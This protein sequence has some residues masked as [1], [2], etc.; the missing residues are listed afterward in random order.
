MKNEY[1]FSAIDFHCPQI[2]EKSLELLSDN[3]NAGDFSKEWWQWKYLKNPFG[4]A[5]GFY[6]EKDG[7]IVALRI[8]IPWIFYYRNK[9]FKAFQAVDTVTA[10]E[11]RKKGLFRELTLI[12]LKKIEKQKAFIFNFPN[13]NSCPGYLSLGWNLKD[14]RKWFLTHTSI[15]AFFTEKK[16]HSFKMPDFVEN[17]RSESLSTPR[18]RDF[19]KWRFEDNPFNDYFTFHNSPKDFLVYKL[20]KLKG[21]TAA[22]IMT[23]DSLDYNKLCRDFISFMAEKAIFFVMYNGTNPGFINFMKK[24]TTAVLLPR[25]IFFAVK[26]IPDSIKD[27]LILELSDSDYF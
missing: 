2:T 18:S 15:K 9:K 6:A 5:L 25:E 16:L 22:V 12:T 17:K 1:T 8:F 27:K 26:N 4:E 20:R 19:F 11:H 14:V 10:T 21:F 24:R 13:K 7:E 23:G 3:F